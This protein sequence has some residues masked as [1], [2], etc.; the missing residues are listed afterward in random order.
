[1]QKWEGLATDVT[2]SGKS[3]MLEPSSHALVSLLVM[4]V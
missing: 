4:K 2:K 1:M 3:D